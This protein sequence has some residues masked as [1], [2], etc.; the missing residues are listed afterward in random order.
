[1][2]E[3]FFLVYVVFVDGLG[4]DDIV[5]MHRVF[6]THCCPVPGAV[7]ASTFVPNHV[8]LAGICESIHTFH[9]LIRFIPQPYMG[10]IEIVPLH[11]L[12]NRGNLS[13]RTGDDER[14]D[15]LRLRHIQLLG[16]SIPFGSIPNSFVPVLDTQAMQGI[17]MYTICKKERDQRCLISTNI[18]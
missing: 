7:L 2:V 4:C 3:S 9:I 15:G 11:E 17:E 12:Q 5:P 16:Q 18:S 10:V 1:M 14:K 8:G 13:K 6:Q